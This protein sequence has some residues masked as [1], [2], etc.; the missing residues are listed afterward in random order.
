MRECDGSVFTDIIRP[1]APRR[2]VALPEKPV[3]ETRRSRHARRVPRLMEVTADGFVPGEDVAAAVIVSH[4]DAT[5]TG[6]AR[7]LIAEQEPASYDVV[8]GD[9]FGSLAV[10]WHLTTTEMVEQVR[11][12]LRPG[13]VY[14]ANLID[15]EPLAFARAELE[16]LRGVFDHVAL[17]ADPYTLSGRGGGNLLAIA[18]DAPLDLPAIEAGFE[19]Q[20]LAWDVVDGDALTEWI[21]DAQVLTDD[22]APVDQLLTPYA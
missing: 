13:G 15:Y 3:P 14:A 21:G 12:V 20:D 22:D 9:A 6:D 1:R 5:G 4:A 8:V 11:R 10:P 17:A 16:T 2:A 7:T 18:S 19:G